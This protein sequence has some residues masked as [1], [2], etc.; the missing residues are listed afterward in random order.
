MRTSALKSPLGLLKVASASGHPSGGGE[1]KP[2]PL[3][4]AGSCCVN[5]GDYSM[6][7]GDCQAKVFCFLCRRIIERQM[8]NLAFSN[9]CEMALKHT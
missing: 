1:L 2:I 8:Q 6:K 3:E 4:A 5:L 7:I 9:G